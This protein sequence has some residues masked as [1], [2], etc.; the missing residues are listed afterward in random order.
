MSWWL[1]I[2]LSGA[3]KEPVA[4]K[5]SAFALDGF[6]L[7]AYLEGEKGK[8]RVEE[9]LRRAAS[10]KSFLYISLINLGEV[11][12]ITEREKGL[13]LAHR[14]VAAIDQLPLQIVPVSRA[15]VMAAA[16]IKALYRISYADAFAVVAARDHHC[17][18]LTGDPEFHSVADDGIIAVEWLPR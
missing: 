13:F 8:P 10:G 1:N 14:V 16:H 3:G 7:L 11:I 9:L 17:V 2:E 18:L 12:Y 15:T 4:A 5:P 6:A